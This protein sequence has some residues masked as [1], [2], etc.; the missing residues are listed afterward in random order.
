MMAVPRR[1]H[2]RHDR[3]PVGV[4]RGAVVVGGQP[5]E[6]AAGDPVVVAYDARAR[7]PLLD[8]QVDGQLAERHIRGGA[9]DELGHHP[10]RAPPPPARAPQETSTPCS[11]VTSA[12]SSAAAACST[13]GGTSGAVSCSA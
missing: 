9:V 2:V 13:G 11:P 7:R 1:P 5:V 12:C 6:E 4:V 10:P 3:K 8:G